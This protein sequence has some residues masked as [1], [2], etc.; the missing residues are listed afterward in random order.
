M[1]DGPCIGV[2][3]YLKS[4]SSSVI[5]TILISRSPW[6]CGP[7]F[8]APD[9]VCQLADMSLMYGFVKT[10]FHEPQ[11]PLEVVSRLRPQALLLE[12]EKK[13]KSHVPKTW[14]ITNIYVPSE[15]GAQL[16]MKQREK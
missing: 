12:K 14:S 13:H 3:E 9:Y 7:S 10:W 16:G 15:N 8:P 1:R 6:D 11:L 4:Q 5:Y 2:S